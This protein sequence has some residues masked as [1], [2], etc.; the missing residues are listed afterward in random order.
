M[1][2]HQMIV[3]IHEYICKS[4]QYILSEDLLFMYFNF[5]LAFLYL[6]MYI[7]TVTKPTITCNMSDGSSSDKSGSEATLKCSADSSQSLNY[8]W[9]QP[10]KIQPG[11]IFSIPLGTEHDDK[12][13][14]C[15]AS[16]QLSK[17]IATFTAKDCYPGKILLI[18]C[19]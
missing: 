1:M 15:T 9:S 8:T 3:L 6:C 2:I 10:G 19:N 17:E 7:D 18:S 16:N 4:M 14:S 5:R 12:V 13:Y 11:Q